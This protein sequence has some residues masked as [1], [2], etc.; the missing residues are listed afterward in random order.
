MIRARLESKAAATARINISHVL[1]NRAH[2]LL[3]AKPLADGSAETQKVAHAVAR[4]LCSMPTVAWVEDFAEKRKAEIEEASARVQGDTKVAAAIDDLIVSDYWAV[5]DLA[6]FGD[7]I[8]E[9]KRKHDAFADLRRRQPQLPQPTAETVGAL[10]RR[11]AEASRAIV[12]DDRQ[13]TVHKFNVPLEK[14]VQCAALLSPLLIVGGFLYCR[15]YYHFFGIST[16]TFFGLSDYLAASIEAVYGAAVA[17]LSGGVG[18]YMSFREYSVA[19]PLRRPLDA[20]WDRGDLPYVLVLALLLSVLMRAAWVDDPIAWRILSLLSLLG[21]LGAAVKY[22]PRFF[23]KPL[24]PTFVVIF[25]AGFL[26]QLICGANYDARTAERGELK[27]VSE[28]QLMVADGE[29][30]TNDQTKL[31]GSSSGYFFLWHR[32]SSSAVIVSRENVQKIF[33]SSIAR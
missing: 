21:S 11:F 17:A 12:A 16:D 28:L 19:K 18:M 30:L 6:S 33:D 26:T 29:F 7:R 22:V 23:E 15:I 9:I 27:G 14:V 31:I 3:Y 1:T 24:A 10:R 13:R 2:E 20:N 5:R 4:K 32:A 8:P 25:I